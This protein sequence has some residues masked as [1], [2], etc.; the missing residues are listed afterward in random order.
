MRTAGRR[1]RRRP[2]RAPVLDLLARARSALLPGWPRSR[3]S[4]ASSSPL[5]PT[6][7]SRRH[8]LRGQLCGP[9]R[10]HGPRPPPAPRSPPPP[11]VSCARS[12]PG[13]RAAS[14]ELRA[15]G[16]HRPVAGEQR[17]APRQ[18][19]GAAVKLAHGAPARGSSAT[20]T[21]ATVGSPS[22]PPPATF[23]R[24]S[25][26]PVSVPNRR[27]CER[28]T[29][30]SATMPA[31]SPCRLAP[32]TRSC[33]AV[34]G[35]QSPLHRPRRELFGAAKVSCSGGGARRCLRTWPHSRPLGPGRRD[36]AGASALGRSTPSGWCRGSCRSRDAIA[37]AVS[38]SPLASG[39][40][41]CAAA[42][43]CRVFAAFGWPRGP[44]RSAGVVLTVLAPRAQFCG[45]H[46]WNVGTCGSRDRGSTGSSSRSRLCCGPCSGIAAVSSSACCRSV[47]FAA[48]GVPRNPGGGPPPAP[49]QG[50]SSPDAPALRTGG[51]AAGRARSSRPAL[52]GLGF[53]LRRGLIVPGYRGAGRCCSGRCWAR[54]PRAGDRFLCGPRGGARSDA[55]GENGARGHPALGNPA[56][57]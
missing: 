31:G 52:E 32:P 27:V 6:V 38:V 8:A 1:Q 2:R 47:G 13:R 56:S 9:R 5:T 21:R 7:A 29:G 41:A 55:G 49:S 12:L 22:L 3:S 44:A 24:K 16:K 37:S 18:V 46:V 23:R 4:S 11:A 28:R 34:A 17:G 26:R 53:R 42:R 35:A 14:A 45:A 30:H 33:V 54:C 50:S 19:R 40:S 48:R 10:G 25:E 36:S 57:R 20:A 15:F 51:R 39:T 43:R